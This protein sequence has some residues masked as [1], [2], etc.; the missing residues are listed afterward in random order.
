MTISKH[1]KNRG[2]KPINLADAFDSTL[3]SHAIYV[4][5]ISEG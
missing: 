4:V 3:R 2:I 5:L 1:L